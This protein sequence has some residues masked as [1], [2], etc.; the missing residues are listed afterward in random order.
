LARIEDINCDLHFYLWYNDCAGTPAA[1]A[2]ECY[3]FA[4]R[5]GDT[6]RLWIVD[7]DGARVVIEA[8]TRKSASPEVEQE[9]QQILDSIQFE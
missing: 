2:R 9:I 8:E 1:D 6:I 3:R 5:P 7:V 4:T